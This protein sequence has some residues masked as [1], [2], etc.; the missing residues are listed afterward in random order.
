MNLEHTAQ[1]R[2][3]VPAPNMMREAFRLFWAAADRYVKR[4][5]LLSL[6][7][8]GT[9]AVLSALAPVALKL[10]VD[11][12]AGGALRTASAWTVGLVML[13]VGA[14]YLSRCST[15][16][17]TL[18]HGYATQRVRRHI[19][20]RLF[21]HLLHLPMRFH[22]GRKT[23]AIGKI[24]EQGLQGYELVLNH[25]LYTILP[26]VVELGV[27]AIV[28]L[29]LGHAVLLIVL[30]VAC[31]AYIAAFNRS[32]VSLRNAAQGASA[33]LVQ[34][35]ALLTDSLLN[36]E[37]VK[38]FNAEPQVSLRYD[39]ALS[40]TEA[41]WRDFFRHRTSSGL[42]VATIFAGSLGVSVLYATTSVIAGQMTLGDF[43]L[44]NAY[45]LRLVQP[46]ELL[47][48]AIRD[49]AQGLAFLT[50]M[51][52]LFREPTEVDTARTAVLQTRG[53]SELEFRKVAFSYGGHDRAILQ[54]VS[55]RVAPGETIAV[56]GVSGSGKSSLI[57]LLFRLYE[58]D[59]GEILLDGEP[60]HQ[61][62]LHA[63][64][65]AIAV[66]PQDTILFNDSIGSNI[67]FGR[68]DA[69]QHEIE[70]AAR[71]AS[72]HEFI[73][74]LPDGYGTLVGERGLRLS[75]GE[76]Q[77]VAIARA[78]LKRPR[79]VVFDEAT[80][81]LDSRT[82]RAILNNL[83][84]VSQNTTTLIIAHRLSTVVRAHRIVVLERGVVVEQGT[85]EQLLGYNRHYA[86]LWRLQQARS[87]ASAPA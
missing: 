25:A 7:L 23:G 86:N 82:E 24:S 42:I 60:I 43:V 83:D 16:L 50:S 3:A 5:L 78:V 15:E 56:V 74:S 19:G 54:D 17:R 18:L 26:V 71:T 55:F 28:L 39:E 29:Q 1:Q 44:I 6:I 79:L 8:V 75:G 46:L 27:V 30:G 34:A 65:S 48:F 13:Y 66:V 33:S 63:V 52:S 20:R 73:A 12:L 9:G 76:R 81:N 80:S 70:E 31:I 38:Y 85:H 67:G 68:P 2:P 77:R 57:R 35:N 41:A 51:L 11:S 62:P 37:V 64:R 45:I 32:A 87:T 84:Q 21:E 40:T 47:G 49:A 36:Q 61:I 53:T 10:L 58:P 69:T 22:T 72:L 59:A 4:K 14:Q